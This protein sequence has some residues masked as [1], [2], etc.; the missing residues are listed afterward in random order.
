M[1]SV[2]PQLWV[3]GS[4]QIWIRSFKWAIV[5][6]CRSRGCKNIWGQSW[7]SQR[8][9]STR[10]VSNPMHPGPAGPADFLSTSKFDLWYFCIFLIYKD[11]QKLI[12]KIW[13]I[14][15]WNLKLKAVVWLLTSLMLGQRTTITYQT[16][17]NG[18][19]FFAAGVDIKYVRT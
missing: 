7:R 13:F 6:S 5:H 19:I 11:A 1:L 16:V 9:L 4:K 12:W 10:P 15:V 2:I 3:P 14:S 8:K 18:C 17:A